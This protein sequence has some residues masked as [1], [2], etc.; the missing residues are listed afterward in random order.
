MLFRSAASTV[1]GVITG[2][3]TSVTGTVTAA[4]TVGGVI[5]GS[6][7]SVTGAVTAA[8]VVGGTLSLIGNTI[9]STD[10]TITIDPANAGNTGHVIIQGNLSVTGWTLMTSARVSSALIPSF[11]Q[12]FFFRSLIFTRL[13]ASTSTSLDWGI[14]ALTFIELPLGLFD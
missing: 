5:T 14:S 4:S 11:L 8:S 9:S 10:N 3:S 13:E 1:G 12:T 6:S 7:A 2:S